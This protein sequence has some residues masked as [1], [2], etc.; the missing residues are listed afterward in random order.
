[1][2]LDD[3]HQRLSELPTLWSVVNRAGGEE[4]NA[5]VNDAR[6]QML[7]RYTP[8]VH[9]Y[10]L[11]ALRDAEAADELSQEFALRL[12][13]GSLR[14]ADPRRGRFRDYLKG[15]LFHLIG[16]YH[17][18]RK[19][20]PLPLPE[21]VDAADSDAELHAS[22]AKFLEDWRGEL[23]ARSWNALARYEEQQGKPYH[24]VLRF[25]AAHVEL[26]SAAMAEQLAPLLGRAVSADWVRQTLHRAR[27]KFSELLL[28]EVL[29]TLDAPTLD[30]LEQEL[31]DLNL[32]EYCRPAFEQLGGRGK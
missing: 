11:G 20:A 24:T 6:R 32:L 22:D 3:P 15:V 13:R 8:V 14:G 25:R 9:R 26:R 5:A 7:E 1:M 30:D 18:R 2:S 19:K 4:A 23:L 16:D 21:G 28:D 12:V 29:Q 27:E 10:L 31:I 17:R